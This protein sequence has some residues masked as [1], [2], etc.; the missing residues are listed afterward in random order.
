MSEEL[1]LK[2]KDALDITFEDDD[3]DRK[4][5]G[6][7]EDAIPILRSLFGCAKGD[8]IDWCKPGLERMLLKNYCLYELNNVSDKF[9]EAYRNEIMQVRSTYEVEQ[10]KKANS[11]TT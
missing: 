4:V 10:W 3:V 1:I 6:I 9:N 5:I 7:I 11:I 2:I 8:E